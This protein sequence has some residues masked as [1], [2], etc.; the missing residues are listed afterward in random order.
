M[1]LKRGKKMWFE[2]SKRTTQLWECFLQIGA[3][4]PDFNSMALSGPACTIT[5]NL[6]EKAKDFTR[7]ASFSEHNKSLLKKKL[8][9]NCKPP[10]LRIGMK[11]KRWNEKFVFDWKEKGKQKGMPAVGFEPTQSYD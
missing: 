9:Y 3:K 2:S 5:S 6:R 7:L 10:F 8:E 4:I 11:N 1:D